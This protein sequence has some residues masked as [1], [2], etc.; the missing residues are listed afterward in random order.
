MALFDKPT[1]VLYF[2]QHGIKENLSRLLRAVEDASDET[3]IT[4]EGF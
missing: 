3:V 2:L 1:I 4:F